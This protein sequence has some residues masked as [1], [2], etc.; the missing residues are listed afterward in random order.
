M[1]RRDFILAC[2]VACVLSSASMTSRS[3]FPIER[4]I[5][6]EVTKVMD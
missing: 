3:A 2:T 4:L 5:A 6:S 1:P